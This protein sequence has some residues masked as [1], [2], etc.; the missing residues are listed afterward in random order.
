V[1]AAAKPAGAKPYVRRDESAPKPPAKRADGEAAKPRWKKA[2]GEARP[3]TGDR[4]KPVPGKAAGSKSFGARGPAKSAG[5]KSFG[6]KPAFAKK[7]APRPADPSDTSRRFTPPRK[8][9]A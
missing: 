4:A 8:P 2:D 1:G 6:D 7:P 3:A 9:K 5:F